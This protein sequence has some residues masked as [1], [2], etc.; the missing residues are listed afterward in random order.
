MNARH[1]LLEGGPADIPEQ[2]PQPD[3]DSDRLRV[4]HLNGYEHYEFTGTY[5]ADTAGPIPV[6]RWIYTTLIAE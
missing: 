1:V 2:Y 6:Y 5:R 4:P 3:D